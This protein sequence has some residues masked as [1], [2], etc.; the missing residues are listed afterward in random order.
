LGKGEIEKR[1]DRAEDRHR[2]SHD[3][4][5]Q[6]PPLFPEIL[7][8][9]LQARQQG[10]ERQREFVDEVQGHQRI[11]GEVS[12]H[13]RPKENAGEKITSELGQ[14]NPC[15]PLPEQV[16]GEQEETEVE[17]KLDLHEGEGLGKPLQKEP[18]EQNQNDENEQMGH[19]SFVT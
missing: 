11:T 1:E 19:F 5:G 14:A 12:Q 18:L 10:D 17:G 16:G 3:Q 7:H 4:P 15:G 13:V 6:E 2:D 9:E 8:P